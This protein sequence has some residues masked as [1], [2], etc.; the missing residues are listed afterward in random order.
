MDL[1]EC[2]IPGPSPPPARAVSS[3]GSVSSQCPPCGRGT[4]PRRCRRSPR[5]PS[6]S[7]SSSDS[8]QVDTKLINVGS[9]GHM[10]EHQTVNQSYSMTLLGSKLFDLELYFYTL[11]YC[12]IIIY[13][14]LFIIF[15]YLLLLYYLFI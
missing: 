5:P 15:T 1:P 4:C 12:F 3:S 14:S 2:R 7:A 6:S 10:V 11:I 9:G 8:L 13:L